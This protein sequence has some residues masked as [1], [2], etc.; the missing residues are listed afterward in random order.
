MTQPSKP[1]TLPS[2]VHSEQQMNLSVVC[3][4]EEAQTDTLSLAPQTRLL[5][6]TQHHATLALP[7][8]GCPG[9]NQLRTRSRKWGCLHMPWGIQPVSNKDCSPYQICIHGTGASKVAM[10][11]QYLRLMNP[12]WARTK[13]SHDENELQCMT[14]P[15]LFPFATSLVK[16]CSYG[17]LFTIMIQRTCG[18]VFQ[19]IHCNNYM[20]AFTVH[21]ALLCSEFGDLYHSTLH[22]IW[23]VQ[24]SSIKYLVL[25]WLIHLFSKAGAIRKI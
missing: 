3:L 7:D 20:R 16:S 10:E 19:P 25:S 15:M 13:K 11:K 6:E 22:H 23:A 12:S 24:I 9:F 4:Q 5:A 1:S 18:Y 8:Q 14:A 17:L 2:T 21:R